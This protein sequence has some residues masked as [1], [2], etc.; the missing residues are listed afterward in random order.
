MLLFQKSCAWLHSAVR[1]KDTI[2][3]K[4]NAH[5]NNNNN[6]NSRVQSSHGFHEFVRSGFAD[7]QGNAK[8][9]NSLVWPV[10]GE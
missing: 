5:F 2:F 9:K 10:S 3:W 6:N 8:K 4:F 7:L 1:K